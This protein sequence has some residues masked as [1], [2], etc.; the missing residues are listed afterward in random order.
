MSR[1]GY[2]DHHIRLLDKR[3]EKII[4]L[5]TPVNFKIALKLKKMTNTTS[6]TR[7]NFLNRFI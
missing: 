4:S 3:V 1:T 7:Q 6:R 2:G 5:L